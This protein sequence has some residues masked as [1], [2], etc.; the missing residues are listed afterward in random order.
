MFCRPLGFELPVYGL[1]WRSFDL[2]TLR[3][4]AKPLTP[5]LLFF[6]AVQ[7]SL[8]ASNLWGSQYE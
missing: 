8:F 5:G 1:E 4:R 7:T 2:W 3:R 6:P